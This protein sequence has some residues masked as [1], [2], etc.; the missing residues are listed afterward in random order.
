MFRTIGQHENERFSSKAPFVI[1][2]IATLLILGGLMML[3][4]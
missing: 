2:G 1:G 3:V 4:A